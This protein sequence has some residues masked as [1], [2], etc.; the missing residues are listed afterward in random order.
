MINARG[1]GWMI[2]ACTN[3]RRHNAGFM[4]VAVPQVRRQRQSVV[5]ERITAARFD[6]RVNRGVRHKIDPLGLVVEDFISALCA[7]PWIAG[8][9]SRR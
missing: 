7:S 6:H 1:V 2:R 8:R 4:D 5:S 3:E 9:Q